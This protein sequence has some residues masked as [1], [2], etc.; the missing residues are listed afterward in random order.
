MLV[1]Y[2]RPLMR[3]RIICTSSK[4]R[5][6]MANKLRAEAEE[7]KAFFTQKLVS[8]LPPC[9]GASES[10]RMGVRRCTKGASQA[11]GR[12]ELSTGDVQIS[13]SS[14]LPRKSYGCPA[15]EHVGLAGRQVPGSIPS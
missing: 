13:S 12:G 10:G 11:V 3:V 2:I 14:S 4:M 1:E 5:A 7:L 8:S 6:K 15:A 9:E